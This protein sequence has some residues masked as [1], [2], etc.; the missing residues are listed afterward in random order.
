MASI[1]RKGFSQSLNQ[2]SF[3][4]KALGHPARI[5]IIDT[6]I[7]NEG[8]ICKEIALDLPIAKST[9]SHHLKILF[10]S[11][12]IGYEKVQSVTHYR[13][14]PL[15]LQNTVKLVSNMAKEIN[16][17]DQNYRETYFKVFPELVE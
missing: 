14:N 15:I 11:G 12:V 6:I 16:A 8:V 13:V 1:Q 3:I 17:F 5:A 9:L 2:Q 4:F 7:R 10:D